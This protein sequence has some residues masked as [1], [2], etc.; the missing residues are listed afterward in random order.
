MTVSGAKE[1]PPGVRAVGVE[2]LVL[3]GLNENGPMVASGVLLKENP[4]PWVD[5]AVD[6]S[7]TPDLGA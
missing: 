6:V 3:I 1:N 5:V 4:L 2:L 7:E